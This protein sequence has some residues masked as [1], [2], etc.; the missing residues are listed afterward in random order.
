MSWTLAILWVAMGNGTLAALTWVW[1]YI[2][3]KRC[4]GSAPKT[5]RMITIWSAPAWVLLIVVNTTILHHDPDVIGWCLAMELPGCLTL[6]GLA[7]LWDRRSY[8]VIISW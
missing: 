2:L 1:G 3:H 7:V 8:R 4:D 6:V 5:R